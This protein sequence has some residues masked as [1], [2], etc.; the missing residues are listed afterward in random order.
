MKAR[1]WGSYSSI[2]FEN[3]T[4]AGVLLDSELTETVSHLDWTPSRI[5][6]CCP[7]KEDWSSNQ[8]Q[9]KNAVLWNFVRSVCCVCTVSGDCVGSGP[10]HIHHACVMWCFSQ[11]L[12]A[13]FHCI[14][15]WHHPGLPASPSAAM[16]RSIT[17]NV[18]STELLQVCIST[19][20]FR[21]FFHV[22]FTGPFITAKEWT[23]HCC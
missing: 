11:V 15:F 17:D 18:A 4:G 12:E 3:H 2:C 23:D 6:W 14:T 5:D 13:S 20:T 8:R 21:P 19:L 22:Q 9:I 16:K 1:L 7:D 10:Q